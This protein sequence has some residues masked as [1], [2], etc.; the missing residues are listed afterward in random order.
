MKLI[1]FFLASFIISSC[2]TNYYVCNVDSPVAFYETP[3]TS[4]VKFYIPQGKQLLLKSGRKKFNSAKFGN[5]EGYILSRNFAVSTKFSSKQIRYLKFQSDSTYYYT[6]NPYSSSST[7]EGSKS[8][9]GTVQVKG[10]YR[11]DGTYVKP[12]TRKAPRK[13]S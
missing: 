3:D 10:Y 12:H 5:N 9:D 2:S 7:V 8:S 11:K 4:K 13:R 6:Y 1:L